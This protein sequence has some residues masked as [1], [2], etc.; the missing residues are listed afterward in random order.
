MEQC[1]ISVIVPVFNVE[2]QLGRCIDSILVQTYRNF[3][4]ILID[5][6]STDRSPQICD[7]FTGRDK[8]VKVIHI[9]NGG[10]SKARN[11]GIKES[12]G[13][14]LTFVD[15]DD[16]LA[17][18]YLSFLAA[19]LKKYNTD[20]AGCQH[21]PFSDER[22]EL[23]CIGKAKEYVFSGQEAVA[24][25][26][27]KKHITCSAWGKLY[28]KELFETIR[29][30]EGRLYEDIGT[31]YRLYMQSQRV[32]QSNERKY[33][34]NQRMGSIMNSAFSGKKMDRVYMAEKIYREVGGIS[35][36]LELA[37]VSRMLISNMI[38]LRELPYG[39]VEFQKEEHMV[40]NNIKKYRKTVLLDKKAKKL[41]RLVAA[42]SYLNMRLLQRL[43]HLYKI[44]SGYIMKEL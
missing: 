28:K 38:V 15:S 2:G 18:D 35:R 42:L 5:D 9:P 40:K 33:F 23:R 44:L 26:C 4:L 10:L 19:L 41:Y 31:T 14:Y 27:Y 32:V 6:G 34:Y 39:S 25:L 22:K 37:A 24:D 8:R 20:I 3:E 17:D 1:L 16:Y 30:P 21:Q 11:L 43:G 29:Y 12:A 13:R 7:N 36:E